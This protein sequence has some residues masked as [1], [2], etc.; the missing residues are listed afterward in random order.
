[1]LIVGCSFTLKTEIGYKKRKNGRVTPRNRGVK[2][3]PPKNRGPFFFSSLCILGY[4]VFVVHYVV[5]KPNAKRFNLS[6]PLHMEA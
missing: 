6:K 3:S 2:N 1:M 5:F 4:V